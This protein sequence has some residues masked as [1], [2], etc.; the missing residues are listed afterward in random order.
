[1]ILTRNSR[2]LPTSASKQ[3]IYLFLGSGVEWR[4]AYGQHG[5]GSKS[6]R[7]ILL[8]S[9]ERQFMTLFPAWWFWQ[10]VL[11]YSRIFIKLQADGNS[12]AS[13]E[14]GRSDCLIECISASVAFLQVRRINIK[15]KK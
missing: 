6:T 10:A 13:R 9:W 11:N 15:I 14:A 4:R 12:L 1:M 3:L 7:A 8:C 2:C 5:L